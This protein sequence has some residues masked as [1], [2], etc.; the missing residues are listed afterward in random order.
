M[1]MPEMIHP[2]LPIYAG[3]KSG[4]DMEEFFLSPHYHNAFEWIRVMKG[5]MEFEISGERVVVDQEETL[6]VNAGQPHIYKG[7]SGRDVSVRLLI[8]RTDA[9]RAEF[10]DSQL[11]QM[12]ADT[13][14]KSVVIRPVSELF[15][16]DMDAIIDLAYHRP[17]AYEYQVVSGY[18]K[19]L[20][21]IY[22]IYQHTNPNDTFSRDTD[23][24]SIR[25]MMAY[26]GENY[27]DQITVDQ[28]AAAG[29]MSR[30]KC[31]RMFRQYLQ[32]SPIEHVQKFRLERSRQLLKNTD[33]PISEIAMRCGF[34]QQSYFNRLFVR[35]FGMTPKEFRT[36]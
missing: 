35:T 20:R 25:E 7:S 17:Q 4:K 19:M 34:N 13:G 8:A 30:S 15:S 3:E 29:N 18:M 32:E 16:S 6:F 10:L 5:T 26:I 33:L 27:Q 1:I 31:T 28:I 9:V 23:L 36:G 24:D 11:E 22:R 2:G 14:F 12:I 21:Q